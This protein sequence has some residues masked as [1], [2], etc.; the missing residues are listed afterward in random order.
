MRSYSG[1]LGD[2]TSAYEHWGRAFSPS[3]SNQSM[4]MEIN[5]EYSLEG[6]LLKL[7]LQFFGHAKSQ[8]TGKDPNAGK[9]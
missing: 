5:P 4:L 2:R 9:H 8:L 7:K 3:E 6:L 1:V